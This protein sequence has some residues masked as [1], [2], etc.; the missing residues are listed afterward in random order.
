MLRN[1]ERLA[2]IR[3]AES[4]IR[5]LLLRAPTRHALQMEV[6]RQFV[7]GVAGRFERER[8]KNLRKMRLYGWMESGGNRSNFCPVSDVTKPLSGW[9]QDTGLTRPILKIPAQSMPSIIF[10]SSLG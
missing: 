5:K 1:S 10:A 4:G 2:D 9:A 8:A 7:G 3:K 6:A